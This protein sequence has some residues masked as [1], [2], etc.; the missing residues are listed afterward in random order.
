MQEP[1]QAD[2]AGISR[3]YDEHFAPLDEGAAYT[4]DD[5]LHFQKSY[6]PKA[7]NRHGRQDFD[8][9]W[10]FKSPNAQD[11]ST[12]L[13]SA[14]SLT[15]NYRADGTQS[16]VTQRIYDALYP[17]GHTYQKV[18]SSGRLGQVALQGGPGLARY[19]NWKLQ[20]KVNDEPV[21]SQTV[22]V[23]KIAALLELPAGSIYQN[24]GNVAYQIRVATFPA[25]WNPRDI[26]WKLRLRNGETQQ[27]IANYEGIFLADPSQPVR[28]FVQP[29]DGLDEET[30]QKPRNTM[31]GTACLRPRFPL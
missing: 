23:R 20:E 9:E 17:K 3:H 25:D 22:P 11:N 14:L 6:T 27:L 24:N 30:G 10:N 26:G 5:W 15:E 2:E 7:P 4:S 21:N 31:N 13:R 1:P 19:G 12:K 18:T 29:W 28:T 8:V 16:V